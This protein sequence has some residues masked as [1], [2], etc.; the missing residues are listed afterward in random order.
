MSRNLLLFAVLAVAGASAQGVYHVGPNVTA[1]TLLYKNEPEYSEEALKAKLEGSVEVRMVVREDGRPRDLRVTKSLG[2]GLDE[3][4]VAAVSRWRFSPGAKDGAAVA[5]ETV[6]TV[7]FRLPMD[8]RQW[9]P[10]GISFTAPQDATRPVLLTAPLPGPAGVPESA[11]VRVSFNVSEQGVPTDI[12]VEYSSGPNWDDEVIAL[13]REW[14][15]QAALQN[16]VAVPSRGLV[17]FSRGEPFLR[18]RKQ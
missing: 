1:P 5:V 2:L 9:R 18:E 12:Q 16:G 15:F 14:R 3:N 13:I 17:D 10:A 11:A 8:E 4:A 6:V 7:N